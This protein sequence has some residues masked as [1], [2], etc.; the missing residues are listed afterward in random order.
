VSVPVAGQPFS[1]AAANLLALAGPLWLAFVGWS[2]VRMWRGQD[3]S[4][5]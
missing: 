4:L 1:V 5:T 3:G 2:S